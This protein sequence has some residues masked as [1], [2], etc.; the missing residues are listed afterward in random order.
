M[1]IGWS[2]WARGRRLRRRRLCRTNGDRR[3]FSSVGAHVAPHLIGFAQALYRWIQLGIYFPRFSIHSSSWKNSKDDVFADIME[4]DSPAGTNEPWMFA[5]CTDEIRRLLQ[6][7]ST[8]VTLLFSLHL[9]ANETSYPI[10]RPLVFHYATD[11]NDRSRSESFEFLLGQDLLVAPVVA[12]NTTILSVYFPGEGTEKW[13]DLHTGKFYEGGKVEVVD[14]PLQGRKGGIP[15]FIRN[16]TGLVLRDV[17]FEENRDVDKGTRTVLLIS[18]P[19]A[20]GVDIVVK[21]KEADGEEDDREVYDFAVHAK[22]TSSSQVTITS[23]AVNPRAMIT[24][25]TVRLH[26]SDTRTL[27]GPPGS[28]VTNNQVTL[29]I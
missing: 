17:T 27:L 1:F 26:E 9:E 6:F 29:S 15:V 5:D 16:N 22:A 7:R 28:T 25:M 24:S 21:W 11:Q 13:C 4:T 10:M 2:V 23:V 8:L 14:A 12:E 19:N 18:D 3:A 20:R